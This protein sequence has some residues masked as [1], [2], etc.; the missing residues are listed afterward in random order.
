MFSYRTT[1]Q[2]TTG[3]TPAELLMKHNLRSRLDLLVPNLS[4]RVFQ[5]QVQQKNIHDKKAQDHQFVVGD[6]VMA[7]NYAVGPKLVRAQI[8]E[9]S[10]P[11][12][13]KVTV[14]TT[15]QIWRRHQDAIHKYVPNDTS[16]NTV[17]RASLSNSE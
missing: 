2:I 14:N 17:I 13:Y 12:S 4:N 8:T 9:Q 7:R 15:N 10:G 16:A 3:S 6:H 11:I 5:A 1:P